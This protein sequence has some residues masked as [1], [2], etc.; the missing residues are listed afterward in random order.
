MMP[1][2]HVALPRDFENRRPVLDHARRIGARQGQPERL[3][4]S[5]APLADCDES[6]RLGRPSIVS[7]CS[8][9]G[10]WRPRERSML[11]T[12]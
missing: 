1:Q 5:W 11:A 12:M 2:H 9:A 3:L 7:A 6:G 4:R 8:S 10:S